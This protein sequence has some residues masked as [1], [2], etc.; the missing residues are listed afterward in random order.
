M[1]PRRLQDRQLLE[2][3]ARSVVNVYAGHHDPEGTRARAYLNDDVIVCVLEDLDGGASAAAAGDDGS[4]DRIAAR[5]AW[6]KANEARFVTAVEELTD[7]RVV[8]FLSAAHTS[9]G[10]GAELF[11]MAPQER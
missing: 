7:R 4:V 5:A 3:I 2:D 9:P 11:F 8:H 1:R 6:Q 10:V